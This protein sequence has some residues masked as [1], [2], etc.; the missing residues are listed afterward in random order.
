M[1]VLVIA[2]AINKVT[3]LIATVVACVL[4]TVAIGVLTATTAT[5]STL[6]KLLWIGGFTILFALGL[7]A[8]EN[9]VSRV[10]IF[11]AAAAYVFIYEL[12]PF[13]VARAN[14]HIYKILRHYGGFHARVAPPN[15]P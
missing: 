3:S 2:K 10:H 5:D 15:R 14:Q 7:V 12:I 9:E 13:H 8:F 4:P 6:Q 11:M 1:S